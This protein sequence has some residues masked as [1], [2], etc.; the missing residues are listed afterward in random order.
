MVSF[1][2][3]P[4]ELWTAAKRGDF[5]WVI[6]LLFLLQYQLQGV[7]FGGYLIEN[8]FFSP[9]SFQLDQLVD[10]AKSDAAGSLDLI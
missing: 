1:A 7:I 3:K 8:V 9:I 2:L 10:L 6:R 4:V 5:P